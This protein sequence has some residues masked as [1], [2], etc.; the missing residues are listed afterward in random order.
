LPNGNVLLAGSFH[1]PGGSCSRVEI[2]DAKSAKWIQARSLT[3]PRNSHTATAL[4]D[5][6]V[7]FVGGEVVNRWEIY[8]V[9]KK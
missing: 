4:P 6:T 1:N 9:S 7:L 3:A 8:D 5:G 2:Y